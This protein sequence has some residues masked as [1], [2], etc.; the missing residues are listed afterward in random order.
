MRPQQAGSAESPEAARQRRTI[1][2]L[3]P[4][5]LYFAA[6]PDAAAAAR[7]AV[8]AWLGAAVTPGM[9]VDVRL[10][11]SELVTN[12]FRHADA[13]DDSAITLRAELSGDALLVEVG[14]GGT[15]G[16]VVRRAPDGG[17]AGGFGLN[18]VD[19]VSRRWGVDRDV[20]TRVWAELAFQPAG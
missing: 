7:A 15:S 12:S 16:R 17:T 14:D 1:A 19:T 9:L 18:L 13:P 10:L 8:G 4:L 20:G 6:T 11:V 5:D 2:A 3:V